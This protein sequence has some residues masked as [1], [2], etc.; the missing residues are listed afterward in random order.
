M[1]V[2]DVLV[3]NAGRRLSS[4]TIDSDDV[5]KKVCWTWHFRVH[6]GRVDCAYL[7]RGPVHEAVN[8]VVGRASRVRHGGDSY[9]PKKVC[10]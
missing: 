9:E 4:E 10:Q 3:R 8:L 7:R 5:E 6:C 1:R 2:Y